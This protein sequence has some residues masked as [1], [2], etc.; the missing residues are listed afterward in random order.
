MI[1]WYLLY[2]VNRSRVKGD[3]TAWVVMFLE[4]KNVTEL[5]QKI[6]EKRKP[7]L[8]WNLTNRV[9]KTG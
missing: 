2:V 4:R 3:K 6:I 5:V 8:A 7:V 9:L 1:R